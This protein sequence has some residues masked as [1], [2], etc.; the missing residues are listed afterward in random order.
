MGNYVERDPGGRGGK[1]RGVNSSREDC[2]G[3]RGIISRK[4]HRKM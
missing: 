4:L 2:M 1:R 3:E